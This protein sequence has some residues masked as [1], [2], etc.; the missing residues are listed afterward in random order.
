MKIFG[1]C[2]VRKNLKFKYGKNLLANN[3]NYFYEYHISN[4]NYQIDTPTN[5]TCTIYI[6]K[7]KPDSKISIANKNYLLKRGMSFDH[8]KNKKVILDKKNVEFLLVGSFKSDKKCKLKITNYLKHYKVKKPWGYELWINGDKSKYVLKEIMIKKKFQTSLQYHRKKTETNMIFNGKAKLI[9]RSKKNKILENTS[10]KDLSNTNLNS[11]SL[12]DV[13]P[14]NL[15]RIK[16]L[17]DIKLYE[18]STNHL[19][20]V[21]R[22]MDDSNRKSG[23]IH[24][25]HKK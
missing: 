18:T 6:I 19:D 1:G 2:E 4:N 9:Y 5:T 25:E 14:Y 12:V 3:K 20:D 16:A 17:T 10:T 23:R 15:H 13:K 21:V 7:S 24:A 8:I 11:V 22:I